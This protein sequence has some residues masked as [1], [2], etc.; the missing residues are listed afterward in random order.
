MLVGNPNICKIL[1]FC[2]QSIVNVGE[3]KTIYTLDV[4]LFPCI[5]IKLP[6]SLFDNVWIEIVSFILS[7][8]YK[9]AENVIA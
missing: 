5:F 2:E 4:A 3:S 9:P 1:S 8:E 7:N 6:L